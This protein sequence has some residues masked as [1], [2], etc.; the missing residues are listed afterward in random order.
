MANASTSIMITFAAPGSGGN[1]NNNGNTNGV[2]T[3]PRNVVI[4]VRDFCDETVI[5]D[6][7]VVV[8][9]A[10]IMPISGPTDAS[11]K[12]AVGILQPGIYNLVMSK[13]GYVSSVADLLANDQFSV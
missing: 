13:A 7:D 1:N 5:E 2:G 9:G 3:V 4:L 12:F 10:G 11:G 6:V 8:S